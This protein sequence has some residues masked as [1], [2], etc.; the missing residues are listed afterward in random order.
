MKIDFG[1]SGESPEQNIFQTRLRCGGDRNRISVTPET[2][3]NPENVDLPD[4][5]GS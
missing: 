4:R 1:N 5:V 2:G 3:R